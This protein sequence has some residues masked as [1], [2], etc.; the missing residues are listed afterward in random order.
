MR[1]ALAVSA[2][3]V[4]VR[5]FAILKTSSQVLEPR[6]PSLSSFG[7]G[8]PRKAFFDQKRGNA[9]RPAAGSVLA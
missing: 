3:H 4:L 1:D 5:H 2:E 7:P 9:A 8:E 6:M